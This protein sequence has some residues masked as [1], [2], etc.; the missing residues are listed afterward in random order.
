MRKEPIPSLPVTPTRLSRP[1]RI[2]A[3]SEQMIAKIKG[4]SKS[5]SRRMPRKKPT[6][7]EDVPYRADKALDRVADVELCPRKH[8]QIPGAAVR[9]AP[10]AN[11]PTPRYRQIPC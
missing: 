1:P 3:T 8:H 10:Q 6:G 2:A 11:G 9:P 4:F 5:P 7:R